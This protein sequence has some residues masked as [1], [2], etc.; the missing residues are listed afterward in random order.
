MAGEAGVN[1]AQYP[2]L[3]WK[4]DIPYVTVRL[5]MGRRNTVMMPKS[6]H[7]LLNKKWLR[8]YSQV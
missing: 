4:S 1:P 2:L 6:E 7:P 8:E 3:Y 5:L